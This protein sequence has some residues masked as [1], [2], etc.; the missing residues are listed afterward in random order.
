MIFLSPIIVIILIII[1]IIIII[2]L[3][4]NT[5]ILINMLHDAYLKRWTASDKETKTKQEN[6]TTQLFYHRFV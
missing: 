5:Y 1:I 4:S 2:I 6:V 3:N